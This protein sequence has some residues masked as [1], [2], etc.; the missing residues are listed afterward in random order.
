MAESCF[1]RFYDENAKECSEECGAKEPCEAEMENRLVGG[2]KLECFGEYSVDNHACKVACKKAEACKAEQAAKTVVGHSP[3]SQGPMKETIEP[4]T[5][6]ETTTPEAVVKEAKKIS[7]SPEAEKIVKMPEPVEGNGETVG[8]ISKKSIV[9]TTIKTI[10]KVTA[11]DMVQAIIDAKLSADTPDE[12][13]KNR[14]LVTMWMS[15]FKK[16]ANMNISREGD[17]YVLSE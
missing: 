17:Y 13:K 10:K 16:K 14:N 9:R 3:R 6:E 12:R 11:D 1:G 15:E 4:L 7:V 8:R 5:L 2:R